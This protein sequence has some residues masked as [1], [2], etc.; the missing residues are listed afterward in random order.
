[1]RV[2]YEESRT[3]RLLVVSLK[4]ERLQDAKIRR[5]ETTVPPA[6][7]DC[8]GRST[9][10]KT[11][12]TPFT[13]FLCHLAYFERI[14]RDL[15]FLQVKESSFWLSKYRKVDIMGVPKVCGSCLLCW[16]SVASGTSHSRVLFIIVANSST[17][18]FRSVTQRLIRS[19]PIM[20]YCLNSII[21]IWT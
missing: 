4:N 7:C 14:R 15:S 16:L 3:V 17:A 1:M 5:S 13:S 6:T 8:V 18:G 2:T 12:L 9:K 19:F 10:L 20:R 21:C 11:L